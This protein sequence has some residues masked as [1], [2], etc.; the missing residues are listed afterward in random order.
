[1]TTHKFAVSQVVL[2]LPD[3]L[4]DAL[5]RGGSQLCCRRRRTRINKAS[6]ARLLQPASQ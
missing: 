6:K 5:K 1:M 2:F 3:G 4:W